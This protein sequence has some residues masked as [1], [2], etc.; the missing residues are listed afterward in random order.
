MKLF[1]RFWIVFALLFCVTASPQT[2]FASTPAVIFSEI[3]WAGSSISSSDEWIELANT[4]GDSVDVSGWT[5]TGAGS[6]GA[7]LTLPANSAIAPYSTYVISNYEYTHT[8][9]ALAT[10]SQYVTATLSL[11]NS[12]F[13]LYLYDAIGAQ[14]D[15]GGR[16]GN[17]IAGRSGSTAQSLDGRYASMVRV[18]GLIAGSETAAWADAQTSA[19]FKEGIA[20]FG[21]P[22]AL[23]VATSAPVNEDAQTTQ[24][25]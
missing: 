19:G 15:V 6:A 25:N 5:I 22:G 7:T 2:A 4:T 23:E 18:D 3:A 8:N 14:I 11:P 13:S 20:D 9:S 16:D 10:K 24:T 21:T 12:G 1:D 17:P